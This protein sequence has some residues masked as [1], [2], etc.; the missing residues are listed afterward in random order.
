MNKDDFIDIQLAASA[1]YASLALHIW[2]PGDDW[3]ALINRAKAKEF[4]ATRAIAISVEEVEKVKSAPTQCESCGGTINQVV[5]RGMDSI[6][7]EYCGAVI[8]L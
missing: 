7:C 1:P 4:D 3:R 8:R 5:L 6:T 2:Q